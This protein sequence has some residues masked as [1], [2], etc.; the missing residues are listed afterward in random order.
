MLEK[1]ENRPNK[2]QPMDMTQKL[3]HVHTNLR[4]AM[5]ARGIEVPALVKHKGYAPITSI[6]E[7]EKATGVKNSGDKEISG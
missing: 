1:I 5:I 3:V 7:W 4:K 2:I 6:Q